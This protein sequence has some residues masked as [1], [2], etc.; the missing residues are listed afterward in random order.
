MDGF[1]L[2]WIAFV[3]IIF[4]AAASPGP[5]FIV[6]VRNSVMHSQK[7]GIFTALGIAFGN[8]FHVTYCIIGVAALIH[9]TEMLFTTI[10]YA[11]VA[12]LIYIGVKSLLSK[13]YDNTKVLQDGDS[14]NRTSLPAAKAFKSGLYTNLLNPKCTMFYLALFTQLIEDTTLLQQMIY[15]LTVAFICIAWFSFVS[16]LLNRRALRRKFMS[17]A[18]WVDRICGGLLIALGVK[19]ALSK[20]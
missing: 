18:K 13:G 1:F 3:L 19:L 16:I 12:Y 14:D 10:K 17:A 4:T 20:V 6:V 2:Q 9:N 5:D 7:A 8:M 11:G 15:A